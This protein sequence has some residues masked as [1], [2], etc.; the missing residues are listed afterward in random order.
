MSTQITTTSTSSS[1]VKRAG[2]IALFAVLALLMG[3]KFSGALISG[4]AS[5][6]HS[7]SAAAYYQGTYPGAPTTVSVSSTA[8]GAVTVTWANPTSTGIPITTY[9]VTDSTGNIVYCTTS[10]IGGA[11][12]ANSCT[13]TPTSTQLSPGDLYVSANGGGFS[14]PSGTGVTIAAPGKPVITATA[15]QASGTIK[16]KFGITGVQKTTGEFVPADSA[17][18]AAKLTT[19]AYNVYYNQTLVC[20]TGP[21]VITAV[22]AATNQGYCT[23]NNSAANFVNG[24]SYHMT[25][26]AVNPAGP[27]VASDATTTSDTAVSA[28]SAPTNATA[29]LNLTNGTVD[30]SFTGS[31]TSGGGTTAYQVTTYDAAKTYPVSTSTTDVTTVTS[32]LPALRPAG[33]TAT[34][35]ISLAQLGTDSELPYNGSFTIT[36]KNGIVST[37]TSTATTNNLYIANLPAAPAT[38]TVSSTASTIAFYWAAVAGVAAGGGYNVQLLTCT[39]AAVNSTCTASGS[40]VFESYSTYNAG[41]AGSGKDTG[42]KYSITVTPG[43]IYNVA[44]SAVTPAGTGPSTMG[45]AQT[46]SATSP[47]APVVKIT[48]VTNNAIT[49]SF[50]APVSSN[51]ST[52]TGYSAILYSVS[53]GATVGTAKA[54]AAPGT[55]TFTGLVAGYS[56]NVYVYAT[57]GTGTDKSDPGYATSPATAGAAPA[58]LAMT[59]TATGATF[60]WTAAVSPASQASYTVMAGST[61]LCTSTGKTCDATTAQLSAAVTAGLGS[62]T[63]TIYGTDASGVTSLVSTLTPAV[64]KPS[65]TGTPQ[66]YTNGNL[67]ATGTLGDI[68]VTWDSV[69]SATSYSIVAV[70]TDGTIKQ[71]TV[72]APA[73]NYVFKG[74]KT[75]KQSWTITI[76]ATNSTGTGT[77]VSVSNNDSAVSAAPDAIVCQIGNSAPAAGNYCNLGVLATYL[78]ATASATLS[79]LTGTAGTSGAALAIGGAGFN[80]LYPQTTPTAGGNALTFFW[81]PSASDVTGN[82]TSGYTGTLVEASGLTLTCKVNKPFAILYGI[83]FPINLCTFVGVPTNQA[84]TFSVTANAPLLDSDGSTTFPANTNSNLLNNDATGILL[85][86]AATNSVSL[87]NNPAQSGPAASVTATPMTT[88]TTA[89]A[90]VTVTW[91]TPT[92]NPQNIA[93]FIIKTTETAGSLASNTAATKD[94]YCSGTVLGLSANKTN[95]TTRTA[96]CVGLTPGATYTFAVYTVSTLTG[97]VDGLS[98][99]ATATATVTN[100]P[101]QMSAPTAVNSGNNK[102]TISWTAPVSPQAITGYKVT[103]TDSANIGFGS[104]SSCTVPVGSDSTVVNTNGG[105]Q[106]ETVTVSAGAT[107]VVAT[108]VTCTFTTLTSASFQV[109]AKNATSL[110][111]QGSAGY[112]LISAKSAA[113]SAVAL[114]STPSAPAHAY[115][116]ANADGSY[117][118]GWNAVTNATSAVTGYTVT[119]YGG[120]SAVT[121]STANTNYTIPA[122][123]MSTTTVYTI[124]VAAVNSVGSSATLTTA[125]AGLKPPTPAT[126]VKYCS[127]ATS[128]TCGSITL[129]WSAGVGDDSASTGTLPVTYNVYATVDGVYTKLASALTGTTFATT[130]SST[131]TDYTVFAVNAAGTSTS[132]AILPT[133]YYAMIAPTAP[134]IAVSGLNSYGAVLSWS[135]ATTA[136][137]GFTGAPNAV[138]SGV[139]GY[140]VTLKGSDGSSIACPALTAASTSCDYSLLLTPGV[141]YSYS[142]TETS[143]GGSAIAQTGAFTAHSAAP[144]SPTITSVTT[145]AAYGGAAGTTE[146]DSITV[147]WTAPTSTGGSPLSGYVV[148]INTGSTKTYCSTALTAASTSCTFIGVTPGATYD[149][150]VAATNVAGQVSAAPTTSISG[151]ATPYSAATATIKATPAMGAANNVTAADGSYAAASAVFTAVYTGSQGGDPTGTGAGTYNG[152]TVDATMVGTALAKKTAAE[153]VTITYPA[154]GSITASW[155]NGAATGNPLTGFLCTATPAVGAA[156]TVTA[157]ATATSCTFTGLANVTYNVKVQAISSYGFTAT[158]GYS[159]PTANYSVAI[160]NPYVNDTPANFGGASMASGS[161][162]AQWLTP[163]I[164]P[165]SSDNIPVT[166]YVVTATDA[167]GN[168][169]TCTAAATKN[170]CTVTGLANS[171]DYTVRVMPV[172][173]AGNSSVYAELVLTTIASSAPTAATIG[174]VTST[175]TGLSVSW[176]APS[177]LGSAAQLVGYWVTATDSLTGKQST[178]AYNATYGV[179]LAPAVSCEISGLVVN[180]NYTVSVTPIAVDANLAK[181]LGPAATKSVVFTSANPEPVI[182]TFSA[183]TAKQKSVSALTGTAKSKINALIGLINDGAKITVS[184]YGKTKAIAL[185]RANAAANYMFNNGAAVHVSIKTVVSKTINTALLTVTSN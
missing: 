33:S 101:A 98:S 134:T 51:G 185:A 176:T 173:A 64:T 151:T 140:T 106:T 107:G 21:I 148:F 132:G 172:N 7:S 103:I 70:G 116:V 55:V 113:A 117:S 159:T 57:Y 160:A 20:T 19:T 5:G 3:A 136:G 163:A 124:T 129:S 61:V 16:V 120:A 10:N 17:G 133:P 144:G 11:G 71:A 45:T 175:S 8:A 60:T 47:T 96:N 34:C 66:S 79:T 75:S 97:A 146:I 152:A 153:Q 84:F 24:V 158:S 58:G 76:A 118:L 183:V 150:S 29:A 81:Y 89:T 130:Y 127:G 142:V 59:L 93:G 138:N 156:V 49:A 62:T 128:T 44:I 82:A 109:A 104:T 168:V 157:F 178:C 179:L 184:G 83:T 73:T 50:T 95:A 137:A 102:V 6:G 23:V 39:N 111:T 125:V 31:A 35:S 12:Q 119:V 149:F 177:S 65:M 54:I 40:P 9:S 100:V 56:Y 37:L 180:D 22:S 115:Y 123:A 86:S 131:T 68:N 139:T 15:V 166:S 165:G 27:S 110:T 46:L 38:V 170:L 77:Y 91:T 72:N 145:A 114:M 141:T 174:T 80:N 167:N 43:A 112:G 78:G 155:T 88:S 164:I 53:G 126:F 28:P 162:S 108:S 122:S 41:A 99:A 121:Y 87:A 161:V 67:T 147:N 2:L 30:I 52:I 26:V 25:V 14:T 169:F 69:S 135:I 85:E 92:V 181:L 42:D 13:W 171:T 94:V 154:Y 32:C 74:I 63:I 90:G 1:L 143:F 105:S 48:S 182:A 36:A 4:P 18:G